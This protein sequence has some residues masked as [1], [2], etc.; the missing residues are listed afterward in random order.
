MLDEIVLNFLLIDAS[1]ITS[2]SQILWKKG[3]YEKSSNLYEDMKYVV[4]KYS[5]ILMKM[6]LQHKETIVHF[7]FNICK[8]ICNP[9][10]QTS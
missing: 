2:Y 4:A 9:S 1:V 8:S 3:T 5:K 7:S 10:Y 6:E